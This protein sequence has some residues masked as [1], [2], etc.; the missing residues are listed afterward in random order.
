MNNFLL[1]HLDAVVQLIILLV[2]GLISFDRLRV[3]QKQ[4]RLDF[5]RLDRK[6]ESLNGKYSDHLTSLVPHQVC[7]AEQTGFRDLIIQVGKVEASLARVEEWVM[8]L[9]AKPACKKEP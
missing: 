9:A 3:G 5:E 6:V 8:G 1:A 2:V 7:L 4:L